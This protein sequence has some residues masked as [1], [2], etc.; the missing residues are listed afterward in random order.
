MI[1]LEGSTRTEYTP[2]IRILNRNSQPKNSNSKSQETNYENQNVAQNR[3][4][5][6]FEMKQRAYNEA[7]KRIMGE[8]ESNAKPS[9]SGGDIEA[10]KSIPI[11]STL[12]PQQ[13]QQNRII[14]N[15]I[16]PDGTKGFT[17]KRS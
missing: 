4:A 12:P 8:C 1:R 16:G 14:R 2:Q 7:R 17:K 6:S 5:M 9:D 3:S 10:S 15:P 11:L 13:S